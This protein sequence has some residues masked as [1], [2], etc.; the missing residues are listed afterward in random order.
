MLLLNIRD[1]LS[2]PEERGYWILPC[3]MGVLNLCSNSAIQAE[4]AQFSLGV[5]SVTPARNGLFAEHL[6]SESGERAPHR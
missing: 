1:W 5:L 2:Q 3:V 4:I 6:L